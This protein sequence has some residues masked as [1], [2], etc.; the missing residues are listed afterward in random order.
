MSKDGYFKSVP[1]YAE[2]SYIKEFDAG[3]TRSGPKF[4]VLDRTAFY[5]EG[6][7]QPSDTGTLRWADGETQVHKV[8]KRGKDIFHYL[9]TDIPV[10]TRVHGAIDWEP[11]L[12]NMR[13]HTGEHLL[14]GLFERAGSGP[15]VYSDLE[16]LEFKPSD[17]TEETVRQVQE[18]FDGI[19]DADIPLSIYYTSREELAGEEDER[20]RG[21]LEKIPRG[22]DELRMVEIPGHALTFCF[23]THVRSTGEIGHLRDL[24]LTVGKKGRK[25]VKFSLE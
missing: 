22:I 10:G 18:E 11:R 15:K 14:T 19:I 6:G 7:G 13:R 16:R 5:P 17:L 2:D 23:G 25:I 8:M 4:V 20:K 9:R 3:V 1:L 12:Y 24:S 21:F